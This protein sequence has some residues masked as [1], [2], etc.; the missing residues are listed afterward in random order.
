MS[1]ITRCPACET[2]FKVVPDQLR[3]SEGWVRCGQCD[4]VFDASFHLLQTL[5]QGSMPALQPLDA[6][7]CE[8]TPDKPGESD[9]S[10]YSVEPVSSASPPADTGPDVEDVDSP[11]GRPAMHEP[12]TPGLAEND[13]AECVSFE[14]PF[15]EAAAIAPIDP[16]LDVDPDGVVDP[17][18]PE[19]EPTAELGEVSFL[20][21][22]RA[23]SAWHKPLVRAT[24]GFLGIALVLGL[25]GQIVFHERDRIAAMQPD[26]QPSLQAACRFLGCTLA[27]LRRIESIVIDSSSFARIRE[28]TYRLSFTLRN[29]AITALA[30]P[31]LELTLTDSLDQPVVR[32]VFLP[33]EL[34]VKSDSLAAGFEWPVSL[35]VSVT[36]AAGVERVAG[37]RLLAFYP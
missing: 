22:S 13:E 24:M 33:A 35:A 12:I 2:L 7:A 37:Y 27:P 19:S 31:A 15:A 3:I 23:N 4:E 32:R 10:D 6:T 14:A 29:S 18:R 17:D 1:L 9:D 30:V 34:G 21:A 36:A 11:D 25:A 16:V 28:D 8:D 20:R 26:L 5:P